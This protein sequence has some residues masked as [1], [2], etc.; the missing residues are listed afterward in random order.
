MFYNYFK[1]AFRNL[2][3]NKGYAAINIVES[4]V[5]IAAYLLIF[6]VIQ[7]ETSFDN[8]HKKKDQIYRS[9]IELHNQYG[10]S[11]AGRSAFPAGSRICIDFPQKSYMLNQ[12]SEISIYV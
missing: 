1:T 6:L 12:K 9:C 2:L 7:F 8:F 3:R 11:Y 10:L 5:G 4:A